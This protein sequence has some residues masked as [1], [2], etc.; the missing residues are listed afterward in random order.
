MADNPTSQNSSKNLSASVKGAV[1]LLLLQIW[2]RMSTFILNQIALRFITREVLGIVALEMELLSSTI[3]FLSRE[4][5]RMALLRSMKDGRDTKNVSDFEKVELQKTVNMTWISIIIG[6]LLSLGISI[7]FTVTASGNYAPVITVFSFAAFCELLSEPMYVIAVNK[8][9]FDLRLRV[10]GFFFDSHL[11]SVAWSFTSQGV[12]K[13]LLTEGDKIL[14]VY[15]ITAAIQGD[16]CFDFKSNPSDILA[17]RTFSSGSAPV[18]LAVYCLYVPIMGVNGITEAYLQALADRKTLTRQSYWMGACW[19][20]FVV[21]A[22]I[23]INILQLGAI[24]L[25]AANCINLLMRIGFA[26]SFVRHKLSL[27]NL[28]PKSPLFWIGFGLVWMSTFYSNQVFGWQ[29]VKQ[30]I[31]HLSVGVAAFGVALVLM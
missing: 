7:Y 11:S 25:V 8:M 19:V 23:S 20:V 5:I 13:A 15:M 4:S 9:Q 30:K 18:V 29:T 31:S 21:T 22:Y 17:G 24:G 26:W 27:Q 1:Q 6:F 2:S 3:L 12:S 14:S 28:F 16:L 10:E